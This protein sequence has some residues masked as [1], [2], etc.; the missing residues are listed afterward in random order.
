MNME[1]PVT[2]KRL[3]RNIISGCFVPTSHY[4]SGENPPGLNER[5]RAAGYNPDAYMMQDGALPTLCY[6]TQDGERV[7]EVLP[8]RDRGRFGGWQVKPLK[9]RDVP[10]SI[11]SDRA[12]SIEY[13]GVEWLV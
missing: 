10:V 11:L 12:D 13:D 8:T 1:C 3:E 4:G 9:R 7:A 5:I 2:G 6:L